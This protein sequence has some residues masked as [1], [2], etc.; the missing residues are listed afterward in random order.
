MKF[1][2]HPISTY[3]QKVL[4]ALNEKGVEFEPQVVALMDPKAKAE[5]RELY[6]LGKIPLLVT[7]EGR[8]IPE[9]SI[10]IEYLDGVAG[11][12]LIFGNAE[13]SRQVRFKDRMF[14]LYLNESVTTL[15]F[16]SMKPASQRDKERIETATFRSNTMYG[17][18]EKELANQP[19]AAGETFSMADCAAAPALFYAQKTA[20]FGGF[21]HVSAYWERLASRPSVQQ[22]IKEAEPHIKAFMSQDAAA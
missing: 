10:I 1:Y 16:Q 9:S 14:D 21:R 2:Y 15:L 11:P 4:I 20:P 22:V 13:Q 7:D 19:F 17:L 18:M 12:K 3:S 5:F 8:K 6:P